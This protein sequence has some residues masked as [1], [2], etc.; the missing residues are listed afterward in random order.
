MISQ[1][2]G[3]FSKLIKKFR[4][5]NGMN[6]NCQMVNINGWAWKL[7][8]WIELLFILIS[9]QCTNGSIMGKNLFSFFNDQINMLIFSV[10]HK[11]HIS[12]GSYLIRIKFHWGQISRVKSG[13]KLFAPDSDGLQILFRGHKSYA[14]KGSHFKVKNRRVVFY[15]NEIINNF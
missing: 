13:H 14:L 8:F 10:S 15:Q 11:Y 3:F 2:S 1:K 7:L 4:F 9:S 12:L 5:Q 6:I